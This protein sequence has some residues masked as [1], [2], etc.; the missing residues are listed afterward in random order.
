MFQRNVKSTIQPSE[1]LTQAVIAGVTDSIQ[2]RKMD[3]Q[4]LQIAGKVGATSVT[5]KIVA[6]ATQSVVKSAMVMSAV[7][8]ICD[9]F[10]LIISKDSNERNQGLFNVAKESTKTGIV[11]KSAEWLMKTGKV[12]SCTAFAVAAGS[13]ET[14]QHIK[15]GNTDKAAQSIV[16]TGVSTLA[17]LAGT[18]LA[19]PV[20]G[21][22]LQT[23][24]SF[25]FGG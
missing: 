1:H 14:M 19:G 15:N 17:Y 9:N 5:N 8:S 10:A 3:Q 25:L 7:T 16:K 6:N 21:L 22:V 2:R 11:L 4:T 23:G 24:V 12:S 18:S 20:G 13:I